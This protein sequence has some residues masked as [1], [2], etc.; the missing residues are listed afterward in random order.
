MKAKSAA[1]P[2]AAPAALPSQQ[3]PTA[4]EQT[5]VAN[6]LKRPAA[7]K[8]NP[9]TAEGPPHKKPAAAKATKKP[10]TGRAYKY[11]YHQKRN[12]WNQT[13]WVR[14]LH[15]QGLKGFACNMYQR[16]SGQWVTLLLHTQ[17]ILYRS[18]WSQA[19]QWMRFVILPRPD[20]SRC[21]N[22]KTVCWYACVALVSLVCSIR[23]QFAKRQRKVLPRRISSSLRPVGGVRSYYIYILYEMSRVDELVLSFACVVSFPFL[24]L[25]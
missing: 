21:V 15:S 5:K 4:P 16:N 25:V 11:C 18:S 12:V 22:L 7:A 20:R 14:T 2:K 19:W 8:A 3:E 1:K 23:R 17:I 13:G 10:P 9:S 6:V 24:L